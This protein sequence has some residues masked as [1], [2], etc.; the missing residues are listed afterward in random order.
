MV[1]S[2]YLHTLVTAEVEHTVTLGGK[3][4][5]ASLREIVINR[6]IIIL[7]I[8]KY[9]IPKFIQVIDRFFQMA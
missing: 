8:G 7:E 6:I 9:F 3:F 4:A 5:N 1:H 2:S